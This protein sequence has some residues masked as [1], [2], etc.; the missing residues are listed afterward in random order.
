M[1][2]ML[3][4]GTAIVVLA[5]VAAPR[6]WPTE[7]SAPVAG[8]EAPHHG[9]VVVEARPAA[10]T[11]TVS[12]EP[13][14]SVRLP[15]GDVVPV[16]PVSTR[17]DGVL[18]VPSDIERAGWWSGGSSV[19]D[20]LGATL[21]AAHVDSRTQRLG[22]FAS[23]LS[24]RLGQRFVLSSATLK[25]TFRVTSMR[26]LPKGSLRRHPW[27]YRASGDR[28]LVLVTCSPPYLP[29]K[30]GYQNL[31]VVTAVLASPPTGRRR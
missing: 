1:R 25:Q 4:V 13:P 2:P 18:G 9:P 28:R 6:W 31:A 29:E 26:V 22:P 14:R 8:A 30:G 21:I 3:A 16:D 10:R 20:P 19:G 5:V 23:L 7:T 17:T 11:G 15:T 12:P 27:M 24:V